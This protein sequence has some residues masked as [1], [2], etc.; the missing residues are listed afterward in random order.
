[1]GKPIVIPGLTQEIDTVVQNLGG[2]PTADEILKSIA[3]CKECV[4]STEGEAHAYLAGNK[5]ALVRA[6][7][8]LMALNKATKALRAALHGYKPP[9]S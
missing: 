4:N 8:N 3:L 6:R 5:S 7:K 2:E 1:M 9:A